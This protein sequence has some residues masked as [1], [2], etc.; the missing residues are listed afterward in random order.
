[1]RRSAPVFSFAV[2]FL[3]LATAITIAATAWVKGFCGDGDI[4]APCSM[5]AFGIALCG[6]LGLGA[7]TTLV[8][9]VAVILRRQISILLK[10]SSS[11]Y[12]SAVLSLVLPVRATGSKFAGAIIIL[13]MWPFS[14]LLVAAAS[15]CFVIW[16]GQVMNKRW[17]YN[18]SNQLPVE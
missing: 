12:V 17:G 13:F 11:L 9:L 7:I 6:L 1:M 4:Q 8:T 3:Y 18:A 10:V 16:L 15:V 5:F 2:S 14:F